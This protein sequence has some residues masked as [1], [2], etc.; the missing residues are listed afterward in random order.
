MSNYGWV[1][2][3]SGVM[4]IWPSSAYGYVDPVAGSMLLQ[5]LLGGIAGL[6][7]F[8]KLFKQRLLRFLGRKRDRE[9]E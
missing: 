6:L 7:V 4:L 5:L 8:V 9:K 2:L 3:L 1:F